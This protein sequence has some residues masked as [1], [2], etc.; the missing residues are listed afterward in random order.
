MMYIITRVDQS[1]NFFAQCRFGISV[2]QD[3]PLWVVKKGK[4]NYTGFT[5]LF[6]N[7]CLGRRHFAFPF[8]EEFGH[9]KP[10]LSISSVIL[11]ALSPKGF[12]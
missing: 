1:L 6:C 12:E 11:I 2:T 9:D 10:C 3:D 4:Q 5:H 8:I 7:I